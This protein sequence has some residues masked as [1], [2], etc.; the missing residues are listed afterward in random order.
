MSGI[1]LETGRTN[2]KQQTRRNILKNTQLLL[3]E[4]SHLS[5][6]DV[7]NASGISRATIYRY[8]SN[9]DILCS[10][11][12]LDINTKLPE[13][14]Y[15]EVKHLDIVNRILAIQDYF[16]ELALSNESAF[17]KYISIYLKED[18]TNQ[19]QP[20]RGSRRTA[21]LKLALAQFKNDL[22]TET[23]NKL[24]A[25]STSLMGIEPLITT[26]DVCNLKNDEVK[27][28]LKWGLKIILE[29]VF[30]K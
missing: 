6:E 7:A 19:K 2:Q 23:Y 12:S 1:S 8:F 4:K 20:L 25:A 28:C 10:E 11:A 18:I 17:R 9:I 27:D 14:I 30:N 5:L 15:E 26:K 24:I 16:N 22:D 29:H 13:T 3:K 21:C